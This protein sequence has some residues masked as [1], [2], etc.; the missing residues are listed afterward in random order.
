MK[1]ICNS[2]DIYVANV[3]R[4]FL[5]QYISVFVHLCTLVWCVFLCIYVGMCVICVRVNYTQLCNI[6]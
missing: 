4:V 5:V 2:F 6:S 1:L 3:N